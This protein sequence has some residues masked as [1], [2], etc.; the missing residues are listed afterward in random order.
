MKYTFINIDLA[1][2]EINSLKEWLED[3]IMERDLQVKEVVLSPDYLP[4][5]DN[6]EDTF[7]VDST[8]GEL[9]VE[10]RKEVG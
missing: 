1:Q 6:T 8:S 7:S 9:Y 2:E 5:T 3:D 10:Y 4:V